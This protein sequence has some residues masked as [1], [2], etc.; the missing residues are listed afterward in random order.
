MIGQI[1]IQEIDRNPP[2]DAD[3][4]VFPDADVDVSSLDLDGD[5]E[6]QGF[7]KGPRIEIGVDFFLLPHGVDGLNEVAPFVEQGHG[8]QRKIEIRCG[9]DVVSGQNP[10]TAAVGRDVFV[11]TNLHAEISDFHGQPSL[12]WACLCVRYQESIPLAHSGERS[13]LKENHRILFFQEFLD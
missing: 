9:F 10:Q 13:K 8:D 4:V 7:H 12:G 1:G 6:G 5:L 2:F 3:L 11:E